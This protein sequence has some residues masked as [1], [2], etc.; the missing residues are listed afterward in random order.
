MTQQKSV[1]DW[2][3]DAHAMEAGGVVTLSDHAEAAGD[4]PEVRAKLEEQRTKI[5]KKSGHREN[6][7]VFYLSG[8]P[9]LRVGVLC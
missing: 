8:P 4:Y 2:L 5:G 6:L 3:K 1:I 9:I 7:D